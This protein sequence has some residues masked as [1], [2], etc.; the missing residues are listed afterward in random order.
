MLAYAAWMGSVPASAQPVAQRG[1]VEGI[2]VGYPQ[3]APN[4]PTQLVGDLLLRQEVFVTPVDWLQLSGGAD[5]RA[6][7]HDQVEDAWRVDFRDRG[8]RRPRM[9]IRRLSADVHRGPIEVE[10]GKQFIRWGR[11][12][13]V[14]PTDRFAPRDFLNV[15]DSDFLAVTGVRASVRAGAETVEGVWVPVFTPSRVP[16]LNQRWTVTPQTATGLTLVDLGA[17]FPDRAQVGVRW[18]HIGR[19]FESAVSFFDGNSDQ[20]D[21]LVSAVPSPS[22]APAADVVRRYPAIRMFGG[23]ATVP[24]TWFTI[25]SEVGYFT[26]PAADTDEYVLYVLQ[27]E[28]QAGEWLLVGGYVG[29]VVTVNRLVRTFAPDRGLSRS[30]IGRASY[31]LDTNRSVAVE[32]AVRQNGD[33]LY[34]KG[35]YSQAYGDHWRTTV[36]AALIRG[37]PTDFIGQYRLNSNFALRL[38]YSY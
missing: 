9:S 15:I 33:G 20:P 23:A 8:I 19:A 37:A 7:S 27:A 11:T 34:V 21:L 26:S 3:P 16:L 30:L 13:I 1:F 2:A 29:E 12:D 38:R 31:T 28:R 24:T 22:G 32:S 18:S 17:A 35:E 36:T 6:N 14:S 5:L 10:V 25:R 4:D